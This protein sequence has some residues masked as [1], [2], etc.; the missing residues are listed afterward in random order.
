MTP[1]HEAFNQSSKGGLWGELENAI[2][3]DAKVDG[4]KVSVM[5]GPIFRESDKVYR[6]VQIPE[7]YWKLIAF[8]DEGDDDFKVA[9]YI[10]SQKDLVFTEGRVDD[11]FHLYQVSLNKLAEETGLDFDEIAKFDSFDT[12]N[13]SAN[14]S[15]LR[16]IQTNKTLFV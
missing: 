9:A 14:G 15:G 1:Q 11:E 13:E 3:A 12:S 16:E 2:F 8:H 10:I 5:A 7:D 6:D 4:L